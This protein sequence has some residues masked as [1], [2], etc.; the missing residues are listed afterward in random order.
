MIVLACGCF[1]I[2]HFGHLK[3]LQMAKS[4]G[5]RLIVALTRDA[6]VN[7]GPGRPVFHERQRR[8]MLMELRCVD[9]VI[10]TSGAEEAIK[11]IR[12]DIYVKGREYE[13][14]LPEKKLVESLGGRVVFTY[15]PVHSSTALVPHL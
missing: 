6:Y 4:M 10:L 14:R 1:D 12:P 8:E 7:K 3:H 9:A 15:T 11:F 5:D 2:L 13:D